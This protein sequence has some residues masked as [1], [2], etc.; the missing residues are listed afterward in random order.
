MRP[1]KRI[2]LA[3]ATLILVNGSASVFSMLLPVLAESVPPRSSEMPPRSEADQLLKAGDAE[4]NAG[5]SEAALATLE[6]ALKSYREAKNQEGEGQAL[7]SLGAVY[8]N[9][10]QY[11]KALALFQQSLAIA[12]AIRNQDLEARSLHNIGFAYEQLKRPSEAISSYQQSLAVSQSSQNRVMVEM[13]TIRLG[14]FYQKL[15]RYVETIALY[16][17]AELLFKEA[18][19]KSRE[20]RAIA[21]IGDVYLEKK[22]YDQAIK[23]YQKSRILV[24]EVAK[25]VKDQGRE[26]RI[27]TKIAFAFYQQNQYEQSVE[28]YQKI[29]STAKAIKD[30]QLEAEILIY[31]GE[32]CLYGLENYTNALKYAQQALTLARKTGNRSLEA[33][34]LSLLGRSLNDSE[35]AQK[36]IDYQLQALAISRE[37]QDRNAEVRDLTNL[38]S[39]YWANR[40]YKKSIEYSLQVLAIAKEVKNRLFEASALSSLGSNAWAL[41]DYQ[42][43]IKYNQQV[44]KIFQELQD[45]DNEIG[46]LHNL[47]SNYIYLGDYQKVLEYSQ[48]IIDLGRK[49][50][51]REYEGVALAFIGFT[52][53]AQGNFQKAL[54]YGQQA[55]S[56]G[57]QVKSPSAEC[58]GLLVLSSAYSGSG[59]YQKAL[60]LAQQSLIAARHPKVRR[61]YVSLEGLALNIIGS[62]YRKTGQ[63]EKAIATY[64]ESLVTN[65][66]DS[67]SAQVGL[68]R[69][70]RS[71]NL[72][73]TAIAYYKQALT[74][75]EQVRR[76]I[77]GLSQ[78]LQSSFLKAVQVDDRSTNADIYRE[79]ADLLISQGRIGEAQQ[80]IELLKVQELNDFSKKTRS[81]IP[82]STVELSPA[83][84]SILAAHN[85]LITFIQKVADCQATQCSDLDALIEQRDRL[86]KAFIARMQGV[87]QQAADDR[88]A[89]IIIRKD[90]FTEQAEKIVAQPKTLLIYPLVLNDRV[91]VLY[92]ATGKVYGDTKCSISQDQLW[93]ATKAF[94]DELRTPSSLDQAKAKSKILYDCLVAPLEG[95]IKDNDIKHLVFAPDLATNYIPLGALYDGK[96]FLIQRFTI[97]NIVDARSTD[98][99]A[100]LPKNPQVLALGMSNGAT[101]GATIFPPLLSVP[102][103]LASIV[104][105]TARKVQ[106]VFSGVELLNANFT[107]TGFA[108]KLRQGNF[109]ILHFATHA[110]FTPTNPV[111]SFLLL[112]DGNPLTIPDIQN[113]DGLGAV[114]LV[115]LSACQTALS[116][117]KGGVEV[118]AISSYFLSRAKTVVASLWNVNDASTALMMQQFYKHLSSG[119]PKAAALQKV[120]QDFI[121]GK[122]TATEADRLRSDILVQ[123]TDP[124]RQVGPQ[125]FAHPYYWAPFI[126]IGNSL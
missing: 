76:K 114:H 92:T 18:N 117:A 126:L 98:T 94:H 67:A 102:P 86:N 42:E 35:D 104:K 121:N 73:I 43:G 60:E 116:D 119:M 90:D 79:L 71:L 66:T 27:M 77:S 39:H 21:L 97:A 88:K 1:L 34:S 107:Q 29:I 85:G 53:I 14:S 69:I 4:R 84:K 48:Q 101:A 40:D 82:L 56:I 109:T 50:D 99:A 75:V 100:Q 113:L 32:V 30:E 72:P 3:M 6:R 2:G 38:S 58:F 24:Q 91:R 124:T 31:L 7:K 22:Q 103:E 105:S 37:L 106:G 57:K 64:R 80:L 11:E 81:P 8:L 68:A 26:V 61:I 20:A 70:Y 93:Q 78:P 25:G 12:R 89:G 96:Q 15:Q 74:K 125:N 10:Q 108:K 54:D 55:L 122:L 120:Q 83:E 115:V 44:L 52:H 59:N 123:S 111:N 19:D 112:G 16:Q 28:Y 13:T 46:V 65:T 51:N 87:E 110:T 45:Y 33:A 41:N 23:F 9:L 17:Q 95:V 47:N 49:V 36:S 118:R 63:T 5:K 62:L